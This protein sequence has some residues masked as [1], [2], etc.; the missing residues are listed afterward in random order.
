METGSAAWLHI[1]DFHFKSGIRYDQDVVTRAL[2][3]SI[4]HITLKSS[5]PDFVIA[6]GDIAFSGASSEYECATEFFDK[7]LSRLSLGRERLVVVPGNHDIDR[8]AGKG[9]ARTLSPDQVDDYFEPG[10]DLIHLSTRQKNF[11]SWYDSYFSGIRRFNKDRTWGE[12][13]TLDLTGGSVD[14]VPLNSATFCLDENDHGKLWLGR[15]SLDTMRQST[16]LR[17]GL[18]IAVLHHPLSWLHPAEIP[19]VKAVLRQTFDCIC[20]G[21]LHDQDI[22]QVVGLAG[23]AVHLSAGA[24]YQ[25]RE[26]PNTCMMVNWEA[27]T[28]T[29]TPFR[30]EDGPMECWTI[31]PSLFNQNQDFKGIYQIVRLKPEPQPTDSTAPG[32]IIS[33]TSDLAQVP[34]R[35]S[36]SALTTKQARVDFEQD[37][38]LSPGGKTLFVAPRL[39]TK[40]QEQC[41]S[42]EDALPVPISEVI[43]N[44]AS[45]LI[46]TRSEYG[47][48]T[49][50]RYLTHLLSEGGISVFRKDA[51]DLPNYRK[52]LEVEFSSLDTKINNVLVLDNVDLERDERLLRE[53]ISA[54]WFSKLIV[55]VPNRSA[56]ASKIVDFQA[57]G[58]DFRHVHLWPVSRSDIRDMSAALFESGDDVFISNIVDKVYSDL[59]DLCIPLTPSNVIMY[60]RILHREGEYH[61]VNRVDIVGRYLSELLRR[62]SDA[63]SDTFNS[64]N[65]ADFISAFT[66]QLYIDK[67]NSFDRNYWFAFSARYQRETLAEFDSSTL[68][69]EALEARIFAEYRQTIFHKYSFFYA[70]YLGRYIASRKDAFDQFIKDEEYLR[71]EG[72]VDV[73]SGLSSD[74]TELVAALTVKLQGCLASFEEKYVPSSFDPL[75]GAI[76]PTKSDEEDKLWKPIAEQIE[77]GPRP[78]PEIDVVKTSLIAERRTADQEVKLAKYSELEFALFKCS[79]LL[80]DALR[81]A[82]DVSGDLKLSALDASLRA[83]HIIFQIGSLLAPKLASKRFFQWGGVAYL[84]F[85]RNDVEPDSPQAKLAIIDSLSWSVARRTSEL[86]GAKKLAGVFRARANATSNIT[87]T[88]IMNFHCILAAKGVGWEESAKA[89]IDKA[90][91]NSFYLCMMSDVLAAQAFHEVIQI[92]DRQALKRLVATI[93]AKR[94]YKR[95]VVGSKAIKKRL[96]VL[97]SKGAFKTDS[98]S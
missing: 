43:E 44:P 84:D 45:F 16:K 58:V 18:R 89:L 17:D 97:D 47:G 81:N 28:L 32:I 8:R 25:T 69:T 85:A 52:K 83:R 13:I 41:E 57:L 96:R 77:K 48:S 65:K 2:I 95:D 9:L 5:V 30:Y 19:N 75:L 7:I 12:P 11:A 36:P 82:D 76:W 94:V 33:D 10:E 6:S 50:C 67:K 15:R 35:A 37:L 22:E 54:K 34:S 23:G 68:L 98:P 71:I 29:V 61:P 42:D 72:V 70:Y 78:T 3:S 39:M 40:A 14:I 87:F 74:N 31:D 4:S 92:K 49:L 24:T 46:E 93:S 63:Y 88:E 60:L 38:F 55:V 90:D 80:M 73:V 27:D 56:R 26:W 20:S 66:Y 79:R 21:H 59:L 64:K 51:R 1:S 53:L 86:L 91:R 62:P